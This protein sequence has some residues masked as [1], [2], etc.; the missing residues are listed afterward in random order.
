[1]HYR[2]YHYFH[3]VFQTHNCRFEKFLLSKGPTY[4]D[5][6]SFNGFTSLEIKIMKIMFM[7]DVAQQLRFKD[8]ISITITKT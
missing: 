7:L 2:L 4:V 8:T 3:E 6:E 5:R 1:M